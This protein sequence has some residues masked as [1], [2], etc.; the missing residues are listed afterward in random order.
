[1]NIVRQIMGISLACF[2]GVLVPVATTVY[3]GV[4]W[5]YHGTPDSS[6][7]EG[8]INRISSTATASAIVG[9]LVGSMGVWLL[10]LMRRKTIGDYVLTGTVLGASTGAAIVAVIMT[11]STGMQQPGDPVVSPSI[12][13]ILRATLMELGSK[14]V[15]MILLPSVSMALGFACYWFVCVRSRI[16]YHKLV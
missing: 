14:S 16:I 12:L 3:G 4:Y 1:M 5:H 6:W 8:L 11:V 9:L 2:V 7:K 10:H 15:G 13:I